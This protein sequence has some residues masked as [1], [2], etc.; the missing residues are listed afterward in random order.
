V[1]TLS[2]ARRLLIL[3][4]H[5]ALE[6]SRINRALADEVTG[7]DRVYVH[8]LYEQYPTFDID[9]D[10]EQALLTNHDI[11]VFQHPFF[12]YSMPA[13]LREWQDL[14]LEHNWAYGHRG[15]ALQ[16]KQLMSAITTGGGE[17]AYCRE[18]PNCFTIRELLAPVEQTAS[19]CGM[20]Y[21]PPFVVHGTHLMLEEEIARHA[22]QYRQVITGLRDGLIDLSV[23]AKE[24]RINRDVARLLGA[25]QSVGG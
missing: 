2:K 8:D 24:P 19:L 25:T 12:W 6:K 15:T 21:L 9:V 11:V 22:Q 5:P 1:L 7:L 3:F 14:V 16:G 10:R 13:V 17:Q 18:G 20:Q 23:V 4:A